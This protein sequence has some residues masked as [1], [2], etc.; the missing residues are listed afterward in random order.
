MGRSFTI[1]SEILLKASVLPLNH[2][3]LNIL[4]DDF[5]YTRI[6]DPSLPPF[7]PK[8]ALISYLMLILMKNVCK[9]IYLQI[10]SHT[11]NV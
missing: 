2:L 7:L 3:V 1:S 5:F 4:S 9:C 11:M 6:S 8:N 10:T